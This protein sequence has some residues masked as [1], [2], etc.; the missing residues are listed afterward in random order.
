M[1]GKFIHP[2]VEK[3]KAHDTSPS[4]AKHAGRETS[5]LYFDPTS[6]Q[7][8]RSIAEFV[9]FQANRFSR[10]PIFNSRHDGDVRSRANRLETDAFSR[11]NHRV[12]RIPTANATDAASNRN[13]HLR[14]TPR[15]GQSTIQPEQ[16]ARPGRSSRRNH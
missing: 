3:Q 16:F 2:R 12:F 15:S 1:S 5:A 8:I 7:N 11:T 10:P 6:C 14:G 9:A 4:I 13:S